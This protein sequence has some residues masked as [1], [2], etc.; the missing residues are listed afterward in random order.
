M[1]RAASET[2]SASTPVMRA[3]VKTASAEHAGVCKRKREDEGEGSSFRKRHK[4]Y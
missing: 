4:E 2:E 1:I 3:S